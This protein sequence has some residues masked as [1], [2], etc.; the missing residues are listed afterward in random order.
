M[1]RQRMKKIIMGILTCVLVATGPFVEGLLHAAD[2]EMP[3]EFLMSWNVPAMPLG[4]I[5]INSLGNIYVGTI[6]PSESWTNIYKYDS[7]GTLLTHWPFFSPHDVSDTYGIAFDSAGNVYIADL[8]DWLIVKFSSDGSQI[9]DWLYP[10]W[11]GG[12]NVVNPL[13]IAIDTADNLYVINMSLYDWK[14]WVTKYAPGGVFVKRWGFNG[15]D[16]PALDSWDASSIAIDSLGFVYVTDVYNHQVHKFSSDGVPIVSWG[17]QGSNEGQFVSPR[18]IAVD[19]LFNV[20]VCDRGNNRVQKFDRNGN[21]LTQWGSFGTGDGYFM[22]PTGIAVDATDNV[23]V[24]DQQT[25]RIQSSVPLQG[26]RR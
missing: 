9:N 1:K 7:S 10:N 8:F 5:A 2:L 4:A 23:Y 18:G 26:R 14:L 6:Q 22:E 11:E 20:Y 16:D 3:P 12:L 17:S 15:T 24:I 13:G 19:Q 25:K 21:F